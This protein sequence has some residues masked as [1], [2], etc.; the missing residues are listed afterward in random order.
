MQ[1]GGPSYKVPLGRRDSTSFATR[2]DVLA[3]LSKINLDATDL[4]A[5]SGGHATARPW[6][7]ACSLRCRATS[8]PSPW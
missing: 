3:V 1:S 2:E 6:R 4:V 8:S 7:T 5:L